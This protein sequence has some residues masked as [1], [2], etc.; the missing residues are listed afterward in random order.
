MRLALFLALVLIV[1]QAVAQ[2]S[3]D[4]LRFFPRGEGD[5]WV[6]H[7][8]GQVCARTP[9][10][11]QDIDATYRFEVVGEAEVDGQVVPV[12][13]GPGGRA[14]VGPLVAD[15]VFAYE[16]IADDGTGEP[17]TPPGACGLRGLIRYAS[18]S[19]PVEVAIGDQ[20][21]SLATAGYNC[22][23]EVQYAEGVGLVRAYSRELSGGGASRTEVWHLE[24]A[25]VGGQTYGRGNTATEPALSELAVRIGPNPTDR[26]ATVRLDLSA[27]VAMLGVDAVDMLGRVV[28]QSER[29]S[30]SAGPVA[31]RLD[32]SRLPAG[33]YAVRVQTRRG[34]AVEV[35]TLTLVR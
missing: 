24:S 2:A 28:W 11:C 7:V 4:W 23:P 20:T 35:E 5:E 9:G 14:I 29:R 32:L 16:V 31:I 17:I 12:V 15:S 27:P 30:A 34:R 22:P 21:Y 8:E 25:R 3:P 10:G 33:V 18:T 13:E 19:E 1:P 6:Y 26:A